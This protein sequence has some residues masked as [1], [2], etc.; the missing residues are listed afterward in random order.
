MVLSGRKSVTLD[1]EVR[2]LLYI[3]STAIS[4]SDLISA[5]E[6]VTTLFEGDSH[7]LVRFKYSCCVRIFQSS[8]IYVVK[9]VVVFVLTVLVVVL[10]DVVVVFAPVLIIVGG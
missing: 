9:Y 10:V 4:N 6:E 1:L 8:S 7:S 2:P 3:Q 5:V